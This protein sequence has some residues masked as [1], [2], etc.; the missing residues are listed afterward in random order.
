MGC[1]SGRIEKLFA[2]LAHACL[3]VNLAKCKFAKVTVCYLGHVVGQGKVCPLRA[4]VRAIDGY[5]PLE[6]KKELMRFLGLVG[7]YHCFCR[8][9]SAVVAPLTNLLKGK[10]KYVWSSECQAA[11]ENVKAL[12]CNA[13]VLAAPQWDRV[14]KIEVDCS[15]VGAGAVLLQRDDLGVDKPV[16]FFFFTESH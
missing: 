3:T 8:N 5:A 7:F 10:V 4:K 13:P 9:F 11:F 1:A 15:Y 14:F 16:C 2:R 12:I 6:T